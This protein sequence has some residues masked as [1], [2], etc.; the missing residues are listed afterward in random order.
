MNLLLVLCVSAARAGDPDED[1]LF[2][3]GPVPA[4]EPPPSEAPS[5][6][7]SDNPYA[8]P[9]AASV[10]DGGQSMPTDS[11]IQR[12]LA[13]VDDRFAIGGRLYLRLNSTVY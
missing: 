2:G 6:A 4:A 5:D 10:L 12:A 11:D 13:A 8:T 3:G 1:E 9:D 7:P